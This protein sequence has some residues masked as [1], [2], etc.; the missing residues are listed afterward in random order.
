[1]RCSR[2]T[3]LLRPFRGLPAFR[4]GI[5]YLS[6]IQGLL[7]QTLQHHVTPGTVSPLKT[8][9]TAHSDITR[10]LGVLD[11]LLR[12]S[13]SQVTSA[14]S[15]NNNTLLSSQ[16][17][18]PRTEPSTLNLLCTEWSRDSYSLD[19]TLPLMCP[20]SPIRRLQPRAHPYP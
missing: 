5:Q 7:Y 13:S 11:P 1:M 17:V 6:G 16:V 3:A 14:H 18:A 8:P 2:N 20:K 4:A 15:Q 9:D 10:S 19:P 12:S